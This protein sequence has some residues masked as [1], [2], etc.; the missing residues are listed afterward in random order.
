MVI[1]RVRRIVNEPALQR[2]EIQAVDIPLP[3]VRMALLCQENSGNF[4]P[5]CFKG[6]LH[7]VLYQLLLSI[8]RPRKSDTSFFFGSITASVS[9]LQQHEC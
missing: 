1:V 6:M 5:R 9:P 4:R 7:D 2:E 3:E 8:H